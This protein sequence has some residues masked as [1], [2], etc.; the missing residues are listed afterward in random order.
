[1]SNIIVDYNAPI[2]D[3]T[4]LVFRSP[5]DCSQITGLQVNYIGG[6]K[7]FMLADAHGNNVG[8]IDHLF[9]ENV[10]VKV[11][12]DV[13]TGMAF[14]QNPDTNSYL[15]Y[16]FG[17]LA[18]S[19]VGEASGNPITL[20][21]SSDRN[22]QGLTLYGTEETASAESVTVKV[23]GKNIAD[24]QKF[25]TDSVISTPTSATYSSNSYGTVIS[26]NTGNSIVVQ[27]SNSPSSDI[28]SYKNGFFCVGFYCQLKAGDVIMLS[29]N[30]KATT[31]P[32]GSYDMTLFLNTQNLGTLYIRNAE[33]GLYYKTITVTNDMA[34]DGWNNM[35]I[36]VGGKSGVFS[37]FQIERSSAYTGFE[38][39]KEPQTLVVPTPNGLQTGEVLEVEEASNLHTYKPTTIITN[40]CGADMK[41]EY[42]A[43]TKTY[44][45]NK[46]NELAATLTALTG[47]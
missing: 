18:D 19:V 23:G 21:D 2:Q 14:V 3:G 38:E 45:D 42:V 37:N 32:L 31:N 17:M 34:K 35:E 41:V 16:R 11:I 15:E 4:E 8:D 36:R 13:T 5:V 43:D 47:V 28:G 7:E 44:I 12:L 25:S 1:M 46:F 30:Y 29:Y 39:Y 33:T 10:V 22:L 20:K 9:A 40:D 6:S 27:Q 24:V 26:A